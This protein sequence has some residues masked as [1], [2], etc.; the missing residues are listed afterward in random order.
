MTRTWTSAHWITCWPSLLTVRMP[1][2]SIPPSKLKWQLNCFWKSYQH[3]TSRLYYGTCCSHTTAV[4]AIFNVYLRHRFT[5]GCQQTTEAVVKV[6]GARCTEEEGWAT[7]SLVSPLPQLLTIL[8]QASW[9]CKIVWKAHQNAPFLWAKLKHSPSPGHPP[10]GLWVLDCPST[11][12]PCWP[13]AENFKHRTGVSKS[14][15]LLQTTKP[16]RIYT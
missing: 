15:A 10:R 1:G 6:R 14:T 13:L 16:K 4:T 2:V 7:T 3:T 11:A 12:E 5:R 9:L 8:Y